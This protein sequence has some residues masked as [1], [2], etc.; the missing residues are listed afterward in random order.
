MSYK[1]PNWA[2]VKLYSSVPKYRKVYPLL[3]LMVMAPWIA[4][5][6]LI[7]FEPEFFVTSRQYFLAPFAVWIYPPVIIALLLAGIKEAATT[8]RN[9]MKNE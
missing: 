4:L 5:I 8:L 9:E 1:L 7:R 3:V 6:C 2:D